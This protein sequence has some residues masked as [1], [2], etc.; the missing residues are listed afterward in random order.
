MQLTFKACVKSFNPRE[1]GGGKH[2]ELVKNMTFYH[3]K[4][5][6]PLVAICCFIYNKVE[7]EF[8]RRSLATQKSK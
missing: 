4:T 5:L 3:C 1:D 2:I 8:M 7:V 6:S